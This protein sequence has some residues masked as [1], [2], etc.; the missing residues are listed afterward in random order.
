MITTPTFTLTPSTTNTIT[1]TPTGTF[2]PTPTGATMLSTPSFTLTPSTTNT[3]TVTPTGTFSTTL[4]ISPVSTATLIP[5]STQTPIWTP[6]VTSTWTA[7]PVTAVAVYPNPATGSTVNILPPPYGGTS[8]VKIV[9]MTVA[10]MKV[11]QETIPQV[12]SGQS[13]TL[14]LISQ[15]N[16]RLANGLYYIIVTTKQ[17]QSIAKLLILR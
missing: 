14:A 17:G 4:T 8:N 16:T 15:W 3:Y 1:V 6:S 7:A 2:S 12:P 5:T 13:I 11:F 10:Y 9:I